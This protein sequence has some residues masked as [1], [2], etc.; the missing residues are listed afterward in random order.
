MRKL[1]KSRKALSPVVAAIILIAVTV[2]V[3]IAVAAWVGALTFSFTTTEQIT[4]TG[5]AWATP[6][7]TTVSNITLT[8]KNTGP[9]ESSIASVKVDGTT[10][11]VTVK[12]T[13]GNSVTFPK[14]M[15]KGAEWSFVVSITGGFQRGTQYSFM[16]VT[17][18]GAQFGPYTLTSP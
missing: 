7:S 11:G 6:G 12:E 13:N 3:S 18:K 15:A 10:T 1:F 5:Y 14:T 4:Y 17:S 2:A 9:A 8:I 16:V